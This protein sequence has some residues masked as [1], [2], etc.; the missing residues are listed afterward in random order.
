MAILKTAFQL[1]HSCRACEALHSIYQPS[2]SFVDVFSAGTIS[3]E[4]E[5]NIQELYL[6]VKI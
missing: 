4:A 1:W 5:L 2:V 3:V 6:Y